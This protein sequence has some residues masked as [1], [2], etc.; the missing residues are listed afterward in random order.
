MNARISKRY[1]AS[2]EEVGIKKQWVVL[3]RCWLVLLEG[4]GMLVSKKNNQAGL[5]PIRNKMHLGKFHPQFEFREIPRAI[6]IPHW[7]PGLELGAARCRWVSV[8][9]LSNRHNSAIHKPADEERCFRDSNYL[10]L[11]VK[12]LSLSWQGA[13]VPGCE[14][15]RGLGRSMLVGVT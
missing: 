10:W 3:Q 12:G 11:F 4:R 6:P 1:W 2:K 13:T 9:F 15:F 7:I 8:F 14:D 5:E